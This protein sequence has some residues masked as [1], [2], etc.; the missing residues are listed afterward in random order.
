MSLKIEID[1]FIINHSQLRARHSVPAK[2]VEYVKN[3]H[4]TNPKA[5]ESSEIAYLE[6]TDDLVQIAPRFRTPLRRFL[7]KSTRFGWLPF[8][9]REP[10]DQTYYDPTTMYYEQNEK[11]EGFVTF[12]ICLVGLIMLIAP[13]WILTHV[14]LPGARLGVITAFIVVF[15]CL[16]Q[17]VTI[18]KPFETLAATAA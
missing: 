7:E 13:L 16:I 5:I 10:Q 8:F 11:L 14:A 3:W 2:D 6:C 4:I 18:A 1:E 12:T 9:R 17:S 15:L